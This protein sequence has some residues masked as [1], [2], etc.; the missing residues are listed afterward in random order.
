ME[1]S[2]W[3]APQYQYLAAASDSSSHS[4]G[5]SRSQ[6]GLAFERV[7]IWPMGSPPFFSQQPWGTVPWP[8]AAVSR[9]RRGNCASVTCVEDKLPPALSRCPTPASSVLCLLRPPWERRRWGFVSVYIFCTFLL[10]T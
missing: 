4:G 1:A 5:G 10:K 3:A 2:F 7:Q 9:G 8:R 6:V